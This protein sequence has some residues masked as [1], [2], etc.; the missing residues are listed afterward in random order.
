MPAFRQAARAGF[1]LEL[2]VKLTA[3][4]V[5]VVFHD[6]TLDRVTP[7][8]GLLAD[9]TLAQLGGCKLDVLGAED[10]LRQLAHLRSAAGRRSRS[11]APSCA[12]CAGP[13]PRR[14]SRSRTSPPIRDFD[15]TPGFATTVTDAIKRSGVPSDQLIIQSFWPPN[16]TVAQQRL[17]GVDTSL[18]SIGAAN[19]SG[20]DLAHAD[21]NQWVSPQWP[22][23]QDYVSEAHA[24]GLRVVPYTVDQPADMRAAFEIGVDALIT[25]DPTRARRVFAR[26]EGPPPRDPGAPDRLAVPAARR[27]AQRAADPAPSTRPG[28]PAGVRDAVQAG[29]SPRPRPTAPSGGRSSA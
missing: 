10:H 8:T 27:L 2:D 23:S 15:A 25:N 22:V 4:G 17:P 21:G 26:A 24:L 1:V 28:S 29:P 12:C 11:C 7:C 19:A 3:D 6:A 13:A 16:L 14:T 9:R 20:I 18:L 5:P